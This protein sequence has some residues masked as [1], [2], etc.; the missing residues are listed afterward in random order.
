MLTPTVGDKSKW[1]AKTTGL[2]MGVLRLHMST[3]KYG[4]HNTHIF[5]VGKRTSILMIGD[6]MSEFLFIHVQLVL[7]LVK[8]DNS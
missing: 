2:S 4:E 6:F 8:F 1:V 7:N 5:F 3:C